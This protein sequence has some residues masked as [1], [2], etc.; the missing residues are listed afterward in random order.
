MTSYT[1][2]GPALQ[3]L[4]ARLLGGKTLH[5][6]NE[7]TAMP[8]HHQLLRFLLRSPLKQAIFF[9]LLLQR[10]EFWV[11]HL[12]HS[13]APFR[14][15]D[16]FRKWLKSQKCGGRG[17]IRM[18]DLNNFVS[19]FSFELLGEVCRVGLFWRGVLSAHS[20]SSWYFTKSGMC[21]A[22]ITS[23]DLREK[24]LTWQ[25]VCLDGCRGLKKGNFKKVCN[26]LH[27]FKFLFYCYHVLK[28]CWFFHQMSHQ[29]REWD[30]SETE[31]KGSK[32]LMEVHDLMQKAPIKWNQENAYVREG[33]TH[34]LWGRELSQSKSGPSAFKS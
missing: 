33:N 26:N 1:S 29:W 15:A 14:K 9:T 22:S 8:C 3:W 4:H 24:M 10:S 25:V 28:G 20:V 17:I 23:E 34:V 12:I 11:P 31:Y 7:I 16:E 6:S 2:Q 27:F 30:N 18:K 19:R 13:L 21:P 32:Y 5:Y